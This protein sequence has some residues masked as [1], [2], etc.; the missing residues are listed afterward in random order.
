MPLS[1]ALQRAHR[2]ARPGTRVIL[3]SDG[4]SAD[5]AAEAP[6]SLLAEHCDVAAIC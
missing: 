5:A 6:L 4:F 2:L 1:Q 3:L